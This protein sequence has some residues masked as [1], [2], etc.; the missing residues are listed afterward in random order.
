MEILGKE[1]S[2]NFLI[3]HLVF[4]CIVRIGLAVSNLMQGFQE[5]T[6]KAFKTFSSN[7]AC[8]SKWNNIKVLEKK[9]EA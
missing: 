2:L 4:P 1:S 7:T 5:I 9:L 3:D 6:K 8:Q